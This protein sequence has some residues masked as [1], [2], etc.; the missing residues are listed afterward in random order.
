M[1]CRLKRTAAVIVLAI[2]AASLFP[3]ESRADDGNTYISQRAK[4][5]LRSQV[6]ALWKEAAEGQRNYHAAFVWFT[7]GSIVV[8]L[9]GALMGYYNQAKL[10]GA[11][12][13]LVTALSSAQAALKIGENL[14]NNKS[15]LIQA[16]ILRSDMEIMDPM[17]RDQRDAIGKRL[18][19]LRA[20]QL[21]LVSA[22]IPS[23][24][25]SGTRKDQAPK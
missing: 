8:G 6:V 18:D 7:V 14:Q 15:L 24:E 2:F 21:T 4:D 20:Q 9:A 25:I 5:D 12:A 23:P 10:A 16:Q 22:A 13:L 17:T 3:Q 1:L 11:A 19:S